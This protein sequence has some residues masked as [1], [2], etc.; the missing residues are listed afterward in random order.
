[1]ARRLNLEAIFELV[2]DRLNQG[3]FAQPGVAESKYES[4]VLDRGQD[5]RSPLSMGSQPILFF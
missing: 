4:S 5:A 3:P 1:M 2:I